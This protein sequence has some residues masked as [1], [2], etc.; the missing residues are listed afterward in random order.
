MS[1]P[2]IAWLL[3]FIVL[4][5]FSKRAPATDCYR[6][7]TGVDLVLNGTNTARASG[8]VD[9]FASNGQLNFEA[10]FTGNINIHQVNPSIDYTSPLSGSGQWI[11]SLSGPADYTT[12]TCYQAFISATSGNTSSS[13]QS[14]ELCTPDPPPPPTPNPGP[15]GCIDNCDTFNSSGAGSDP[16]VIS[17]RGPYNLSGIDDPVTFDIRAVGHPLSIAWTARNADVAFL[18]LDRNG[19][20]RID[21]GSELFGNA[22]PLSQGGL[23]PNGFVALAQYDLNGDGVIDASD[24]VWSDLL[25]WVDANHN[26]ISEPGELRH[27]AD[28]SI[29]A[30]EI[31]HHWTGRRDQSGNWFGYEGHLHEGKSVRSFYDVFFMKAP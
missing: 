4:V 2:R 29:T 6:L 19:N 30:I 16:L 8:E 1:R 12:K 22:T 17:L 23:A 13:N 14:S 5:A 21:D 3:A 28:S 20:G 31:Q 15:G 10:S 26:G 27:I 11:A 24:P 25:L 7:G 9:C 18:A